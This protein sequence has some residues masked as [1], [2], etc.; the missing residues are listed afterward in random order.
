MLGKARFTIG[1]IVGSI[2]FG[3]SAFAATTILATNTPSGGYLLCFN[4]KTKAVTFP[5]TL[6]CPSGTKA[7]D[8]GASWGKD[9][10]QGE[11]GPEGPQ[12]IQGIP[13]IQGVRGDTGPQGATGDRGLKG[14]TGAQGI[15]GIK[16]STGDKGAT[17]AQGDTGPRG[18]T[19]ATGAQGAQGPS[20][21]GSKYYWSK[22]SSTIDI[23]ADGA[24]NSGST[25]VKKIMLT[26]KSTDV[27]SGLYKL[28]GHVIGLWADAAD[29]GSLLQCYFQ[30]S[31]DYDSNGSQQWGRTSTERK[32]WNNVDINVSGDWYTSLNSTMYL[33]C[34]TSGTL[35][36][37]QVLVDL[38]SVVNGG[39]IG[40]SSGSPS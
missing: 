24:I 6:S 18:F 5:G 15:Q 7:L 27:P 23:V 39:P 20:G 14:E 37:L 13:G 8:L 26:L 12:G 1:F 17:G 38:V 22:N 10:V 31:S 2:V 29:E 3:S 34:R 36:G 21:T 40:G 11:Q 32:S 28:S 33:V 30:S 35:K 9:G 4:S 19:G 16:G 25:M